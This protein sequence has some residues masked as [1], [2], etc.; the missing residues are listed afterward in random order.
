MIGS[1]L[2]TFLSGGFGTIEGLSGANTSFFTGKS[3]SVEDMASYVA[4]NQLD[5]SQLFWTQGEDGK[6]RIHLS[7]EQWK[8]VTKVDQNLFY[9]DGEGYIDLGL[10][11][12]YTFDDQG[13]LV[14]DTDGTWIAVN[15]QTVAYYHTDTTESPEGTVITGYIPAMVNGVRAR[16][17]VVF[18]PAHPKGYISGYET[19]YHEGE[20]ETVAKADGELQMGDT[21]DFLCDY[22]SYDGEFEDSFLLGEQM[23]M[24]ED[25]IISNLFLPE[26]QI[27]VTYVFTDLYRQQHWSEAF[28]E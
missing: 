4:E 28:T 27:R 11:N 8:L 9:D 13:N 25:I 17:L 26:G 18:D 19:D 24:G 3:L 6:P 15:G 22:Y 12:L 21:I 2:N 23:T 7:D 16:L 10:D 5:D 1:L 20:T 14:A